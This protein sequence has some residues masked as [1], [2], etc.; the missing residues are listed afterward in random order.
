MRGGRV[1]L[2]LFEKGRPWDGE[3]VYLELEKGGFLLGL[4]NEDQRG[5]GVSR[6][7]SGI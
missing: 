5:E 3:R 1:D 7:A 4:G 6:K 2:W